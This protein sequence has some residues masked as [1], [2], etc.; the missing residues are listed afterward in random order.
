MGAGIS[1]PLIF[2]TAA[3]AGSASTTRFF[4]A[5]L[6]PMPLWRFPPIGDKFQ[7]LRDG[8]SGSQL[9]SAEETR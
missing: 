4:R 5:R 2:S 1:A 9:Y 7:S 3:G 6:K 8:A